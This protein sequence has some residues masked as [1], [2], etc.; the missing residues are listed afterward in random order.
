MKYDQGFINLSQVVIN[1]LKE[2]INKGSYFCFRDPSEA[3]QLIRV[4]DLFCD[5]ELKYIQVSF[6]NDPEKDQTITLRV[7]DKPLG[8][9]KNLI[10]YL[11]QEIKDYIDNLKITNTP[12][13]LR[14]LVRDNFF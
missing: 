6:Y 7:F 3:K 5:I 1:S 9:D 2:G 13:N 11:D 4:L 12:E 10:E 14:L 8:S